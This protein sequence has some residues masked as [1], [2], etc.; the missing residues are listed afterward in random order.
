M[1]GEDHVTTRRRQSSTRQGALGEI[2]P[3]TA[4]PCTFSPQNWRNASLSL[5]F[6]TATV[7]DSYTRARGARLMGSVL[8]TVLC[9]TA[10]HTGEMSGE[11]SRAR[12]RGGA[13]AG[14]PKLIDAARELCYRAQ[15]VSTPE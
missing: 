8:A 2:Y 7:A 9:N 13:R 5:V 1:P 11:D 15:Q 4:W 6:V 3:V 10:R 12:S 14:C